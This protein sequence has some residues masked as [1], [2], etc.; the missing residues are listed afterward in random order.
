MPERSLVDVHA[1]FTTPHYIEVAKAAGHVEPDGM[2]EAYWPGWSAEDHL[3]LMNRIGVGK[4]VL[5]ISSP[6]ITFSTTSVPD[7]AAEVNNVAAAVTRDHPDRFGFFASLPMLEENAA[8]E[9]IRRSFEE[10][11][12]AG[13]V[14]MSN[15]AGAY[16]GDPR[17]EPVLAEL[18]RRRAVLFIHPTTPI[19]FDALSFGRPAPMVEFLFDT[20]RTVFDFALSG[21]AARF[22]NIE[23]IIPHMGGTIPILA[24]RVEL[25]RGITDEPTGSLDEFLARA[26]WDLAGA[27]NSSQLRALIDLAEGGSL[28]YGSDYNWTRSAAVEKLADGLDERLAPLVPEWRRTVG[29]NADR[30]LNRV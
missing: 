22:P 7:L 30:L 28:L 2:P 19:G 4:S 1:H 14:V 21:A 24:S 15:T 11:G 8:R 12:A 23:V 17:L 18:D 26:W 25:F 13:V 29:A 6:G 5:S 20:A 10:L 3:A 16:L 27:P 9:E